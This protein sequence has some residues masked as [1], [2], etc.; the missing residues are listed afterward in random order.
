[1][2][3]FPEI[4]EVEIRILDACDDNKTLTLTEAYLFPAIVKATV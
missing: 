4:P 3:T 1:M 2:K